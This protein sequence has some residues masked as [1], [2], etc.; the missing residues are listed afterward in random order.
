MALGDPERTSTRTDY[1]GVG[2]VW[3]YPSKRPRFSFGV[4]VGTSSGHSAG[5]VG[6]ATGTNHIEEGT[7]VV[8][9]GGR[10][11]AIEAPAKAR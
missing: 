9:A 5:A 11:S 3:I 4:G 7:R 6:V 1:D 8:F 2:E 10:V